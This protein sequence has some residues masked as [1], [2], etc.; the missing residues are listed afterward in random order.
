MTYETSAANLIINDKSLKVFPL[1]WATRQGC[2]LPLLLFNFVLEVLVRA[3]RQE[4]EV[5]DMQIAK[6]KVKHV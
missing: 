1:R 4:K 2:L 6:D 5:K 3:L